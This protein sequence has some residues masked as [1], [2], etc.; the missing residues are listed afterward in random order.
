MSAITSKGKTL[1][2]N[3]RGQT[4][5][6][7][8]GFLEV[9]RLGPEDFIGAASWEC[10]GREVQGGGRGFSTYK[11]YISESTYLGLVIIP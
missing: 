11:E 2:K 5:G 3:L 9:V 4:V 1:W 6:V 8:E 7:K 10:A